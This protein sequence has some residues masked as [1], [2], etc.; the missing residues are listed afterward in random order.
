MEDVQLHGWLLLIVQQVVNYVQNMVI[1]NSAAQTLSQ[2][3]ITPTPFPLS[4]TEGC[5]LQGY[6]ATHKARPKYCFF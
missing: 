2:L 4:D 3:Y 5:G 6:N 1:L